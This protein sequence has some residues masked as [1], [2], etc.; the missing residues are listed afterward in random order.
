MSLQAIGVH[1]LFILGIRGRLSP[2]IAPII[3]FLIWVFIV[4]AVSL[5]FVTHPGLTE[6]KGKYYPYFGNTKTWCWITDP[7]DGERL[8]LS[9][10]WMWLSVLGNCFI[11]GLLAL[12]VMG[13]VVLEYGRWK[14]WV[15]REE[16][17][18]NSQS[19]KG[20][21]EVARLLL[22]CVVYGKFL[23]KRCDSILLPESYPVVYVLTVGICI[24]AELVFNPDN[25]LARFFCILSLDG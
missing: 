22:W 10:V 7:F 19:G 24:P 5:P 21:A 3:I 11:Y 23:P 6:Y 16:R 20:V 17:I 8:G 12:D 9:Y 15:P 13:F 18:Q 2:K 14:I 1:T 25:F 4:L